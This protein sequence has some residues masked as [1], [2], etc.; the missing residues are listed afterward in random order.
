MN[1][2]IK[3]FLLDA[4]PGIVIALITAG[5]PTLVALRKLKKV[6]PM[7]NA[8]KLSG[9]ALK[10]VETYRLEVCALKEEIGKLKDDFEAKNAEQ[11]KEIDRGKKRVTR[12]SRVVR[13][14]YNGSLL[15]VKQIEEHALVPVWK[16]SVSA[17]EL[18]KSITNGD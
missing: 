8:A 6:T 3:Q 1:E 16:P 11:D 17:D 5:V 4:L 10:I 7:D 18:L 12:L 2:V 15:L 14:L 13:D 9:E